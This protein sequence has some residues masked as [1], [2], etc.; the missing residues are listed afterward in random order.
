MITPNRQ[1]ISSRARTLAQKLDAL[2]QGLHDAHAAN[3]RLTNR[4]IRAARRLHATACEGRVIANRIF[5]W[6]SFTFNQFVVWT[7]EALE[8][9]DTT[10]YSNDWAADKLAEIELSLARH[11]SDVAVLSRVLD[12]LS[13]A[14]VIKRETAA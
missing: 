14:G 12:R 1:E 3:A 4:E 6:S 5:I 7:G 8:E 13:R 2:D 11:Q 9:V 10:G